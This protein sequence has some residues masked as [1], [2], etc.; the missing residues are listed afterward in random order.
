MSDRVALRRCK[1]LACM[2]D[3]LVCPNPTCRDL[4]HHV[5]LEK[6]AVELS[7]CKDMGCFSPEHVMCPQCYNSTI[8][9]K[10]TEDHLRKT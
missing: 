6:D 9:L 1:D 10:L 4:L 2:D 8:H 3:H 7:L 5:F